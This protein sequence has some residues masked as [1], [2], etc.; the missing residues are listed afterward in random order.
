MFGA[1]KKVAKKAHRV[2]P[3]S[4]AK[5][6][7]VSLI[8]PTQ[9]VVQVN[10]QGLAEKEKLVL[11]GRG[12]VVEADSQGEGLIG[13][14]ESLWKVSDYR[15]DKKVDEKYSE[16]YTMPHWAVCEPEDRVPIR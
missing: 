7:T 15:K 1:K 3:S 14:P 5:S 13:P 9:V 16:L 4:D 11:R 8:M 2:A 10:D 12:R 6:D